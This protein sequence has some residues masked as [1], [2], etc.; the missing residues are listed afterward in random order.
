MRALFVPVAALACAGLATYAARGL[1]EGKEQPIVVEAAPVAAPVVYQKILV[2]ARGL[3]VGTFVH[4]GDT[5]WQ[6]WPDF[7]VPDGYVVQGE[8]AF[9]AMGAVVRLPVP[10]GQP[11]LPEHLVKPNE[12]GFLAAVLDPG[13]RA[14][15][16]PVDEATSNA[17]LIFPGDRVDLILTRVDNENAGGGVGTRSSRTVLRDLRVL[18]MGRNIAVLAAQDAGAPPVRTVTLEATPDGAQT[19]ALVNEL[20]K[21][22]L[23]L[24]SL[25]RDDA[26]RPDLRDGVAEADLLPRKTTHVVERLVV[27]RGSSK[28]DTQIKENLP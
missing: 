18:A 26:A 15:T 1:I 24:R 9:D 8:G 11:L 20:G 17:G 22:S 14:I 13:M 19:V 5:V 21:L 25:A 12:R 16:I 10:A 7:G 27:I 2:A 23:S 28:E 4:D 3:E 6:E